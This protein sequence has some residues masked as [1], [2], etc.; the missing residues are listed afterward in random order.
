MAQG[1]DTGGPKGM[2]EPRVAPL[3]GG[4]L[5]RHDVHLRSLVKPAANGR[6]FGRVVAEAELPQ[7]FLQRGVL[8]AGDHGGDR[9]HVARRAQGGQMRMVEQESDRDPAGEGIGDAELIQLLRHRRKGVQ[10]NGAHGR[11]A[12]CARCFRRSLAHGPGR[13]RA[14][15]RPAPA[16]RTAWHPSARRRAQSGTRA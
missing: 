8:D 12:S 2:L 1:L 16:T 14:A 9:V 13:R 11:R 7:L 4:V 5:G 10:I 6:A 3:P 15:R